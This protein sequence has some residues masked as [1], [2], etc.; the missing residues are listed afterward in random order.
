MINQPRAIDCLQRYELDALVATSPV[1]VTYVTGYYSWLAGQFKEYMVRPGGSADLLPSF[2]VF[3]A[4]GHTSLA[5]DATMACNAMDLEVD[6]IRFFGGGMLDHSAPPVELPDRL[7][8]LHTSMTTE[9]YGASPVDALKDVLLDASLANGRIGID[10]DTLASTTFEAIQHALPDVQWR[11]ASNLIRWIRMVK[12][13]E[14]IERLRRATQIAEEAAH[15]A[16]ADAKVGGSLLEM[17]QR[18][19]TE[20]AAQGAEP[21]HFAYSARGMGIATESDYRLA[22]DDILYVDYGCVF[23]YCCSD[24][25]LTLSMGPPS[26][27]HQRSYDALYACLQAGSEAMRPGVNTSAILD[28]MWSVLCEHDIRV[29]FP[30]G[31][32]IGLEVRDYPILV[33]DTRLRIKDDC[34]DEPAD[35]PLEESMV[36]NLEAPIFIP[37]TASLHIEQTFLV[38]SDGAALLTPQE[39]GAP[40]LP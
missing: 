7:K 8:S 10:R 25:G 34:I 38:E 36:L 33:G 13:K 14:E 9:P 17:R 37:G 1:N 5:I 2:G 20:L 26:D 4:A 3:T 39:R 21:D 23:G 30:H 6:R 16:L 11:D 28:A 35:L 15:I 31:H 27:S 29:S 12:T 19:Q 18:F 40:F 22:P 24:S 32:G